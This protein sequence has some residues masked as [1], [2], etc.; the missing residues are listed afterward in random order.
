V[1]RICTCTI[2][3]ISIAGIVNA[4]RSPGI[5]IIGLRGFGYTGHCFMPGVQPA[6]GR[7]LAIIV[8][9][10][11]TEVAVRPLLVEV[12][13]HPG[14]ATEALRPVVLQRRWRRQDCN[15]FVEPACKA[16]FAIALALYTNRFC[17]NKATLTASAY[18][19]PRSEER[20]VGKEC[21]SGAA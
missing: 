18:N 17:R 13:N 20:R 11:P 15:L 14:F 8:I 4:T 19:D 21:R 10:L 6:V 7:S 3:D 16:L 5:R 2:E 9:V 1:E 12:F